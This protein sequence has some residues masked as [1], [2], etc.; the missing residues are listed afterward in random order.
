M[1]YKEITALGIPF[2]DLKAGKVY[3]IFDPIRLLKVPFGFIQAFYFLLKAKPDVILS[4]GGYLAVPVV[5]IGWVLGIP[6]LTHEQTIVVGYANKVVSRFAKKVLISWPQSGKFFPKDKVVYSGL[7]IRACIFEAR[8]QNFIADNELPTIYI[9]A[10]KS[11]SHF[12]NE[13]IK[14]SLPE[15]L[16]FCNV[17]H[18]CGDNSVH[19][20]YGQLSELYSQIKSLSIGIYFLRKF[21]T[22]EEV[23]EAYARAAFVISRSGAHTVTELLT[24]QKPCLLIPIPWVSHNEQYENAKL[25]VNA[26]LAKIL[27]QQSLTHQSFVENI[28]NFLVNL[29]NYYLKD[30]EILKL[31]KNEAAEDIANETIKLAQKS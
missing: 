19:K 28:R 8:T 9:T 20:D 12:I 1:E 11:G 24:L 5:L 26:G 14:S 21:I 16:G 25:L 3:R 18:Q 23:G 29:R 31:I 4:F 13:L 15:L 7:P 27:A 22:D 2:F 6:A 17:I 30:E 10:G